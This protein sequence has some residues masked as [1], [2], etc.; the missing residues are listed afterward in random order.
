M[1]IQRKILAAAL[2]LAFSAA[3]FGAA[4][5]QGK[6]GGKAPRLLV[7]QMGVQL[8]ETLEGEDVLHTFKLRNAGDGELQILSVRP[9]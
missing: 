6:P 3:L 2:V 4:F 8:G 7:D 1:N 9:G 5:A